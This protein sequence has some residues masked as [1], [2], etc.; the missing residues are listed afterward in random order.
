MESFKTP[1]ET[2]TLPS[3]GL[4]YPEGH[5]Y[6]SGQVEIRYMTAADEDIIRSEKKMRA[7]T[8]I[9][10][11]MKALMVDNSGFED[12]IVGDKNAI[13]IACRILGYGSEYKV[14]MGTK[15]YTFDLDKIQNK[16]FDESLFS[17]RKNEFDYKLP[18]RGNTVTFKILTHA[19][20]KKI[21]EE[22]EGLKKIIA[23]GADLPRTTTQLKYIITSIDGDNS[24]KTIREYVDKHLL[25]RDSISLRKY[26]QSMMPDVNMVQE[27]DGKE[28]MIP[29]TMKFFYV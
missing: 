19:D 18:V 16:S 20:E 10:D 11:L 13:M 12:L 27:I 4:V 2:V 22:L 21:N 28:V 23:K 6:A 1:T 8:A 29:I 9:D 7:G 3:K 14:S 5:P 24:T 25:A 17:N 15:T 26:M